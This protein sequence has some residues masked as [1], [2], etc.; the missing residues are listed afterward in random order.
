MADCFKYSRPES[1][2][3]HPQWV[4]DYVNDVERRGI[5]THSFVM[6]RHG[7]VFAEGYWKP[8][9]KNFFHRMY[10]VSKSFVSAAIGVL[11]YE[12]RISLDD[13][14]ADYFPD[15]L[16]ENPH[17]Y[18]TETTIRDMLMMATPHASSTYT[19]EDMDWLK[20]FFQPHK[21]PNHPAGTVFSYD[22]SGSY[23]LDVLVERLTGKTFLEYLKDKMLRDLGFS[24]ESWCVEAPEGYAWGG[25]GV[26]CTTLDMARLAYVFLNGGCVDGK[27]YMSEEYAKAATSKQIDN[28]T[29]GHQDSVNGQGY[30]YQIWMT[31]DGGFAFYGMGGQMAICFPEKDF[32]F[33]CNS[34]T[35]GR[36]Y[37]YEMFESLW[38]TIIKRLDQEEIPFED[39][40]L[41]NMQY[42]LDNLS[43]I[44]PKGELDSA[45][46][47][48]VNG[49]E[50]SL[51]ENSMKIRKLRFEL[52]KD[53]GILYLDTARGEKKFCFGFGHYVED[54]FPEDHYDS[55]R[56]NYPK[57]SG[58][59]CMNTAVWSEPQKLVLKC[60]V[61]DDYFG[62]LTATFCFKGNQIGVRMIKNAEHFMDEYKGFAGGE[63][64]K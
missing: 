35:Q 63:R 39:A 22:T 6:I 58:Y 45:L 19:F 60:F 29:D 26:Q 2:G 41:A 52:E 7:N 13:R 24:E 53:G 3:V 18:I 34:D 16:P 20:T 12:G 21:T 15:Q 54:I 4:I 11:C 17:P 28:C 59:R 44:L 50:Y 32:L 14:I 38:D 48:F 30:G 61:I 40:A 64:I 56:I 62:N 10:S 23:V 49:A 36:M 37:Q 9:S 42:T 46:A 51:H 57:G 5:M 33:A 55:K 25:S 47:S 27:R 8:F 1:V 43:C 31:R